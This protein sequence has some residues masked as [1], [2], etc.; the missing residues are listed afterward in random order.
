MD[1]SDEADC[2]IMSLDE[3]YDKKYP[4]MKNT[5]VAISMEIL[6]ILDIKE[7]EMEYR[8]FLKMRLIWNDE[9]IIFRN[10]KPDERDNQL[11]VK[12][13]D[14]LWTPKLLFL[15]SDQIGVVRATSGDI[16][17]AEV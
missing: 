4:A 10:L 8:V 3:G 9:R 15:N 1:G 5:T 7:L 12:D 2:K 14:K 11:N 6:D 13:I 16:L 17:S